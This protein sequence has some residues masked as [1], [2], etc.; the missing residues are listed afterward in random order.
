MRPQSCS[1]GCGVF[2]STGTVENS[3]AFQRRV[4]SEY[5][6]SPAGTVGLSAIKNGNRKTMRHPVSRPGGTRGRGRHPGVKTPGYCRVVPAGTKNGGVRKFR[7]WSFKHRLMR[8][9]P[10]SCA[11]EI[12]RNNERNPAK[13]NRVTKN[14]KMRNSL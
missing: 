5:V 2:G 12:N 13:S 3:P 10:R 11:V 14:K 4:K 1:R 8:R 9:C 7:E 6:P